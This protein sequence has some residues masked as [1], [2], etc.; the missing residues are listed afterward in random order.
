VRRL[1]TFNAIY[2][3][4]LFKWCAARLRFVGLQLASTGHFHMGQPFT[5]NS[6]FD[7]NLDPHARAPRP[8]LFEIFFLTMLTRRRAS[9]RVPGKSWSLFTTRRAV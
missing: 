2:D 1:L 6:V 7:V 4:P 3:F 8:V 5:V 9:V